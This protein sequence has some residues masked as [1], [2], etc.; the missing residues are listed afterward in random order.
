MLANSTKEQINTITEKA[1]P[2]SY[3]VVATEEKPTSL[4]LKVEIKTMD[5]AEKKSVTAALDS[6]AT[7][8]CIN[9]DYAKSCQCNLIK[10]TQPIP[11]YNIDG[12]PNEAGLITEVVSLILHYKKHSE[13]TT[14]AIMSLG[15]QKM[16]LRHSWLHKHNPEIDW[17]MGEVKTSRCPLHCCSGCRDELCKERIAQKTKA[18][19][20]D[21]C[22]VGP[23]PEIDHDIADNTE[24]DD[25]CLEHEPLS[26][27]EGDHILATGLFPCPSMDIWASS[28]ILQRLAE[29]FQA[30]TEESWTT[31][32][33]SPLCSPSNPSM[34]FQNPRNGTMPLGWYLDLH[35]LV[36]RYTPLSPVEKKELDAF[37]KENLET[38]HIQP[39]K[40]PISSL[41]FFIKKKDGSLRLVQDYWALNAVT[42]KNKYPLPLI[43]K[44]INKLQGVKYFTKLD[45]HW[46][47][48]NVWMK[49]GDKWKATFWTNRGLYCK[50]NY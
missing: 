11:V 10:L 44:L 30:N 34:S 31:S 33:S 1:L 4:R 20:I 5:T 15:R 25:S 42:I 45:V 17:G 38:G 29:A 14:F 7:G 43:S 19:R 6:S 32:K 22:S 23:V 12:S 49:V 26:I 13:W 41:V 36:A 3:I 35:H 37:L 24:L 50:G 27:E 40:S 16:I 46:G 2:K 9:R 18:R 8:E 39:S 21:I 28:T 47:F 48:N